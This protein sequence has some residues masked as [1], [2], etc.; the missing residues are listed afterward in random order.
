M[1]AAKGGLPFGCQ[2]ARPV[3]APRVALTVSVRRI[4]SL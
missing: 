2:L 4:S 3:T 1:W